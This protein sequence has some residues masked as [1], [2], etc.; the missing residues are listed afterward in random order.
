MLNE[1]KHLTRFFAEFTLSVTRFF[2]WL[3]MTGEGLRMT[4]FSPF[5][6]AYFLPLA[7]AQLIIPF[8][9]IREDF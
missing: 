9:L 8:F 2:A 5:L 1:V 6:N 7:P 4:S 3:R